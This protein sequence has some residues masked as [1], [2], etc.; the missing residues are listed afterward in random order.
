MIDEQDLPEL[1]VSPKVH[2]LAEKRLIL[3]SEVREVIAH[4]E[5]TSEKIKDSKSGHFIAAFRPHAVTY[6]VEYSPDGDVFAVHNVYSHRMKVGTDQ[7]S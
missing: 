5:T 1:N 3:L 2:A 6:W 7:P 4:A